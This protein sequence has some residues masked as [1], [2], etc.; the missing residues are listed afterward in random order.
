MKTPKLETWYEW[1]DYWCLRLF[2]LVLYSL[3]YLV[4][5]VAAYWSAFHFDF[6][7]CA[8]A[9]SMCWL[10]GFLTLVQFWFFNAVY[11]FFERFRF[12]PA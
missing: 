2:V 11:R 9:V 3:V 4:F 1:F 5:Q 7:S 6:W 12:D 8:K 10:A